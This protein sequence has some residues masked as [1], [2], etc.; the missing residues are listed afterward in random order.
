MVVWRSL[1]LEGVAD[2]MLLPAQ[3]LAAEERREG[4]VGALAG[5]REQAVH[6]YRSESL[7]KARLSL[8]SRHVSQR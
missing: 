1:E 2:I 6:S 5:F 3:V 8:G 4:V 7:G